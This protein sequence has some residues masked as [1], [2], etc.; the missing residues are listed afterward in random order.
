LLF[1]YD[2]DGWHLNIPLNGVVVQDT[3]ADLDE[4]H[5]KRSKHQRKHCN[6]TMA[7][8]YDYRLQHRDTDGIALL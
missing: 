1:P 8:F 5:A 4:N 2:E 6:M 3:N 7:E